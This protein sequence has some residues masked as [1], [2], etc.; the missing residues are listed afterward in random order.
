MAAQDQF[1]W[2]TALRLPSV[3]L[4]ILSNLIPLA[5][6]LFFGWNIG[7]ILL[8]Y[9]VETVLIGLFNLPKLLTA[10][11]TDGAPNGQKPGLLG[12]LFLA[13]FFTVHYGGFNAGHF[14]FLNDMFDFPPITAVPWIA[15]LGLGLSHFASLVINWFG[16]GEFKDSSA[17]MQMFKPYG[18]IVIM[19]VVIL[20]GGA[21]VQAFGAPILALI[22]LIA[23][24]IMI[25]VAT[26][27]VSHTAAAGKVMVPV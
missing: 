7:L 8:I 22:L 15:V 5:G 4:L 11:G 23:L 18:R 13:G 26:H 1:E 24:K 27:M 16:K 2:K 21:M 12:R 19:H 20:I 3:W 25:D 14:A 17:N 10:Q 6:V 9:W